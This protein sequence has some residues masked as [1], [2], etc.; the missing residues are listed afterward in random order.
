MLTTGLDARACQTATQ[1][2]RTA[3]RLLR[4]NRGT[5]VLGGKITPRWDPDG[6]RFWYTVDTEYGKCFVV[7]DPAA[8]TRDQAF[9]HDRLA[10]ALE[11]A[12][13]RQVDAAALPFFAIAVTAGAVEFDAF[14]GQWR[15]A[16]DTYACQR[17]GDTV[18]ANPLEIPSP[19]GRYGLDRVEHNLRVR[20]PDGAGERMLTSDGSADLDYGANPDYL[21]YSSLFDKIGLPHLP[22]AVAWSPDSTRVLTHRTDQ[23]GVRLTHLERVA[24]ADGSAPGLLTQRCAFP[25]DERMP[26]AELVVIDIETGEVVRAKAEPLPMPMM[27]PIFQRWAWWADDSSAVYYLSWSPDYRT[28]RLHRLDPVTGEVRTVLTET[29]ATRV[30]PAQS[31]MQPPIVRVLPERGEVL[32][33]SQRDGWGHLYRYGLDDGGMRTQVTSGEWGVQEILHVDEQ[34]QVVY[35]VAAGLVAA[36]P[37]RRSVCRIGLDGTGFARIIDDELDHVV[38]VAPG[39]AHFVD[40]ASTTD[41]PPVITARS[42]DGRVLVELE[43]ADITGLR[44]TGWTPPER[45]RAASADGETEV[46]GLLYKPH[47]FDLAGSYPV[48]DTPYGIPVGTRVSPAFDPGFYGY[49]AEAL[50]ALGFAV[51]AVDGLGSPG[52]S[53]AFHDASYENLSGACGLSDHVS[54]LR[55]LAATRPWLDL[56]RVGITGTSGGGF[57]A[58]RAMLDFPEVFGVGVAESGMHDFRY[59]NVGLAEPYNGLFDADTYAAASNVEHADRLTGKLLLIHGGLDDRVPPQQ[60]LR[61]A[62]RLV[63]ADKDFE[64]FLVPGA[65]HIYFGYE[66]QVIRR[67]WAF[68]IRH[69]LGTELPAD[70]RLQPAPMD[71]E[72]LAALFG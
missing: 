24:P 41:S 23:R 29:G 64:L 62:Q 25:G 13:G 4:H 1:P 55:E 66:H 67:R 56:R 50:A 34:Q 38:T 70:F 36:D 3:E 47:G 21:M 14:G 61:L 33:Y 42:W 51:I 71:T 10:K 44:E 68:L 2:Y 20:L 53:K 72:A 19:D 9:D 54:A 65:D 22:P 39:A 6:T 45:F 52:R 18:Q 48:I 7:A 69:L 57:A 15:C 60:S 59:L 58:V 5:L 40:S 26:L 16:L 11:A 27:S 31:Q 28:L 8:G 63:A 12:S 46:W 49:D 30:E 32:W 17:T 37:Y 43:R 35:F